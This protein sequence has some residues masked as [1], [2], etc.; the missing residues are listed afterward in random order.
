MTTQNS[1][2]VLHNWRCFSESSFYLPEESFCIIDSNGSGKTSLLSAIF[3][4]ITKKPWPQTRLIDHLKVNCQYFGISSKNY[5]WS[6]TGQIS[7]SSRL[8]TK[9]IKPRG[10]IFFLGRNFN[11]SDQLPIILTY[12]PTDNYWFS[13]SR[14][15]KL[16]NID[17]LISQIY[18]KDYEQNLKLLSK[19]LES[20]HKL[21]K[22]CLETGAVADEILV[23]TL[24]E[25]IFKLSVKI[26]EVRRVFFQIINEFL[27]QFSCWIACPVKNWKLNWEITDGFGVRTKV[28]YLNQSMIQNLKPDFDLIWH[29]ELTSGKILYGA[30]RDD[31]KIISNHIPV[32]NILSRGE[33]RLL[34]LFIKTIMAKRVIENPVREIWWFLDDLFNE[35]DAKREKIIQKEL[36]EKCDFSIQT[37]TRPASHSFKVFT[38]SQLT[39]G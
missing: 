21:I 19:N 30:S 33:T 24:S 10:E 39:K 20:K 31:F 8:I 9:H 35:L 2:L 27:E 26:W 32:E 5:N 15:Q 1:N 29:K 28:S 18:Q 11:L 34:V 23:S 37:G 25:N 36:L 16:S 7:S 17:G 14:N 12:Q 38:L 13:L 4:L 6:L 3:S 22:H